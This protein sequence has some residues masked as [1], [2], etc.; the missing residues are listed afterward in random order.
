MAEP[1][2]RLEPPLGENSVAWT[3]P[4]DNAANGAIYAAVTFHR[5]TIAVIQLV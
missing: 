5:R 4:R 3:G 2:F 1:R